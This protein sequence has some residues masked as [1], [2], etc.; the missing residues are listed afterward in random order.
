VKIMLGP[1]SRGNGC[2]CP[3]G[4]DTKGIIGSGPDTLPRFDHV[5]S[6]QLFLFY[7]CNDKPP[8]TPFL[9]RGA[10]GDY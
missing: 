3:Y 7:F 4:E 1:R 9:E 8:L 2:V 10:R 5:I 6:P